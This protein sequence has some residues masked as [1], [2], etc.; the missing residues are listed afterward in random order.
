[1]LDDGWHAISLWFPQMPN[2][3][4]APHHSP[5]SAPQA[6]PNAQ[7]VL[8]PS[9][10]P[11]VAVGQAMACGSATSMNHP[12][13]HGELVT[14]ACKTMGMRRP[15]GAEQGVVVP[16]A[17]GCYHLW[18]QERW[19]WPSIIRDPVLVASITCRGLILEL[20]RLQGAVDTRMR[21]PR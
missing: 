20:V 5:G 14:P 2:I 12:T 9:N 8:M 18:T 17:L 13:R 1:M 3:P 16:R 7:Q 15:E 21:L 19:Q 11:R 4:S 10:Q 6:A